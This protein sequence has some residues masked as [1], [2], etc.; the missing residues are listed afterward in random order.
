MTLGNS[1][2]TFSLTVLKESEN[3]Q[4]AKEKSVNK[5]KTAIIS[6]MKNVLFSARNYLAN[7]MVPKLNR[8]TLLKDCMLINILH[9]NTT[10]KHTTYEHHT[11]IREFQQSMSEVHSACADSIYCKLVEAIESFGLKLTNL[12]VHLSGVVTRLRDVTKGLLA[13]HCIAHRLALGTGSAADQVRYFVKFQEVI[14]GIYKYFAYSP[15]NMAR[16]EVIQGVL[17]GNGTRVKQVFHTRWLSFEGSVQAHVTNYP[18]LF[19]YVAHFL[20]DILTQLAILCKSYQR[21]DIDFTEVNPLLHSTVEVIEDLANTCSGS[22]ITTFLADVPSEPSIDSAGLCAF[23]YK[24]H[25]IRDGATPRS[26]AV[27]ACQSFVRNV[28]MH[29]RDRFTEEDDAVILGALT[30]LFDPTMFSSQQDLWDTVD[31]VVSYLTSWGQGSVSTLTQEVKSFMAFARVQVLQ[32]VKVF[33]C[34]RDLIQLA[35]RCKSKYPLVWL[36]KEFWL[37]LFKQ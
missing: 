5:S 37:H 8:A 28:V 31:T 25:T 1:S 6:A 29:L 13:T 12:M 16:L 26:E 19:L 3:M 23:E 27:S 21:S 35:V 7:S 14:S 20:A 15:R 36:L 30:K 2:H 10:P 18:S 24:G 34:V 11:S 33:S 22:N 17:S 9:M 4:V 32:N